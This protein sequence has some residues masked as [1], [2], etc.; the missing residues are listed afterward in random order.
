MNLSQK[1]R[2]FLLLKHEELKNDYRTKDGRDRQ[3]CVELAFDMARLLIAEG[4]SPY[5]VRFF[6]EDFVEHGFLQVRALAPQIYGGRIEFSTHT[7]T[8]SDDMVFDPM[9]GRPVPLSRYSQIAFG[10]DVRYKV[11]FEHAAI[12][13]QLEHDQLR[14]TQ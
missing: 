2:E 13:A 5:I 14:L 11:A 1:V 10:N 6:G 3:G 9:I 4:R 7:V 8:V 12:R